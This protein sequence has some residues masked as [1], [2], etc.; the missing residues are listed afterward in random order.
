MR[1]QIHDQ[2]TTG[3]SHNAS[4]FEHDYANCTLGGVNKFE[5]VILCKCT[6]MDMMHTGTSLQE[7]EQ[8]EQEVRDLVSELQESQCREQQLLEHL[9][10]AAASWRNGQGLKGLGHLT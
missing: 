6:L 9:R 5:T 1:Q 7:L 3:A 10:H 4:D 2:R 8:W